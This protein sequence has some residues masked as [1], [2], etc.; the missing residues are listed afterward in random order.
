MTGSF[1]LTQGAGQKLEFAINRNN[2]GVSEVE[3]LSSGDNF[4]KVALLASGA[5]EL[6]MKPIVK[7]VQKF[8]KSLGTVT[9]NVTEAVNASEFFKTRDGLCVEELP[10][11]RFISDARAG[12]GPVHLSKH[13][14]N[15]E[16]LDSE[17]QTELPRTHAFLAGEFCQILATMLT[18]QWGGKNGYLIND[19][20]ANIFYVW[21][22]H[23]MKEFAVY[24]NWNSVSRDWHVSVWGLVGHRWDAGLVVFSPA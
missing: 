14:L 3:W 21:D 16:L 8:L 15:N 4:R 24:V 7:A 23:E 5:A 11:S 20:K 22:K 12:T 19:G 1:I 17:I 13:R 10:F 9:V 2:V 18:K 6:V